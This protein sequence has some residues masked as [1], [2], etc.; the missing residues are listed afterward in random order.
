MKQHS[1]KASD[2]QF[3]RLFRWI[4]GLQISSDVKL[5]FARLLDLA[6][7][8]QDVKASRRFLRAWLS[9]SDARLRRA[10]SELEKL[11]WLSR[12][13]SVTPAGDRAATEWKLPRIVIQS[14]ETVRVEGVS[15]TGHGVPRRN[16]VSRTGQSRPHKQNTQE[17]GSHAHARTRSSTVADA[18]SPTL[19]GAERISLERR[20]GQIQAELVEACRKKETARGAALFAEQCRHH[21]A[22]GWTEPRRPKWLGVREET[23]RPDDSEHEITDEERRAFCEQVRRLRESLQHSTPNEQ[24]PRVPV[25]RTRT[26]PANSPP[27]TYGNPDHSSSEN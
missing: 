17:G 23:P 25:S 11:G 26:I 16:T 19:S 27:L 18:T 3:I 21:S 4:A 22:L 1:I 9:W 6:D 14:R 7:G 13:S 5:L 10:S 20:L 12:K 8:E 2:A 15:Y 24:Q